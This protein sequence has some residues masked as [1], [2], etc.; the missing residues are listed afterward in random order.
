MADGTV[1]VV[2]TPTVCSK[3]NIDAENLG[4]VVIDDSASGV[5][6]KDALKFTDQRRHPAR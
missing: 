1:D 2:I 4:L 5:E 6:H 3:P